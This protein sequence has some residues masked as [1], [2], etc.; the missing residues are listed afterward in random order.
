MLSVV[1]TSWWTEK[2]RLAFHKAMEEYELSQL[3]TSEQAVAHHNLGIMHSNRRRFEAAEKAYRLAS[4]IDPQFVPARFNLAML[5]NQQENKAAAMRVLQEVTELAPDMADA[6]YSLGLLLAEDERRMKD[7][8][9]A[10]ARAAKLSPKQGRV[11]YN[12][13]LALQRLGKPNEAE[14]ALLT[15][16]NLEPTARDYVYALAVLCSQEKRWPDALRWTDQ[17]SRLDPSN[18]EWRE[19]RQLII[20]SAK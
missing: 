1:P 14:T 2:Q 13:G 19:L 10:L 5:Y 17:L 6:H 9:Q 15:A 4:K 16:H 18:L 7:S 8:A 12:H 20:R 3:A 11:H